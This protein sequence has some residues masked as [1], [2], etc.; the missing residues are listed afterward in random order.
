MPKLTLPGPLPTTDAGNNA[1]PV[2]G[3][4]LQITDTAWHQICPLNLKRSKFLVTNPKFDDTGA[5]NA[6]ILYVVRANEQPTQAAG[7]KYNRG[8]E[9]D[10]GEILAENGN[11]ASNAIFVRSSN[12]I[13]NPFT[14]YFEEG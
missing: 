11:C 12:P 14:I 1:V 13:A 6:N 9:V 10:P 5:A 3:Q 8:I 7:S 4:Y 2:N